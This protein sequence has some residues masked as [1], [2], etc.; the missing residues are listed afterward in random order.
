MKTFDLLLYFNIIS[1]LF[2]GL[3]CLFAKRMVIEFDRFRLTK[4]QRILTG[5]FQLLGVGGLLI[6]NQND[7]IGMAAALGLAILMT[8]GFIV[9]LKIKDG[10]YRSSPALIYLILNLIIAYRFYVKLS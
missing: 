5:I 3:T 7:L 2:F 1:F 8:A 6:G 4:N 9:R 10:I